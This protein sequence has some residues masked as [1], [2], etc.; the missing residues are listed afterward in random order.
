MLRQIS[1]LILVSILMPIFFI[2][3]GPAMAVSLSPSIS[4]S[5]NSFNFLDNKESDSMVQVV[6]F[7]ENE[8]R[9]SSPDKMAPLKSVDFKTR[10]KMVINDLKAGNSNLLES[11]S[12]QIV[13]LSPGVVIKRFWIAPALAFEIP[14]SKIDELTQIPGVVSIFENGA[15]EYIQPVESKLVASKTNGTY[16]HLSAMNIPALWDMGIDGTGRLICNFDTGVDGE[17]PALKSKWHGNSATSSSSWF[18]PHQSETLPQDMVGHGTQ[19]M[20]I[21]VG[22][23]DIDTIGVAPGA[24]WIGAAVVDQGQTLNKTISDILSAFEWVVDPDGDPET[25]ADMPDVLLNSWGIPTTIMEPCDE[26]FFQVIDNVEAAGIVTIFAAGNE[27]PTP[28]SLRNPANSARSPLNSFA[29]GAIDHNTNQIAS[30]SSRGPSSCDSSSIKPEVVAPGVGIYTTAKGGGYRYSTGTSMAAPIIAGLVVL[31]RQY[32]P[33]ATV[34]EIKNA[35]IESATDLG[36]QGEDNDYGHGL[37]DAVKALALLPRPSS[38]EIIVTGTIIGDDG[39]ADPEEIFNL[40]IRL[41]AV[42]NSF[43]SLTGYLYSNDARVNV[44]ANQ[45]PFIFPTNSIQAAN[46]PPYIL[47]VNGPILHGEVIAFK[48]AIDLPFGIPYD[49]L[50]FNLTIGTPPSGHMLTHVSSSVEMTVSDFGQYGMAENSIYPAGGRGFRYNGSDNLLYEAGIII[51]RNSLQLSSSIRDSLGRA[52]Q[53]DF[54]PVSDITVDYS[55]SSEGFKSFA[56]YTDSQADIQI[57]IT[58]GQTI[59]SF[60]QAGED[61][62]FIIRYFLKNSSG[63]PITDLSF[64]FFADFD[65]GETGDQIGI[66]SEN[67]LYYQMSDQYT[68]GV[69]PLTDIKGILAIDN[70]NEKLNI[71][72]LEKFGYLNHTGIEINETE[73]GD[74]MSILSFGPYNIQ[75]QDSVEVVLVIAVGQ[76]LTDIQYF[77]NLGAERYFGITD[78]ENQAN[79]LPSDFELGQNYPNPFNPATT[80]S[81]QINRATI[82]RLSI[83]NILGQEVA[84]IFEKQTEPGNYTVRWAGIDTN[85]SKVASGI[86]FY[87]LETDSSVDTKKMLMLK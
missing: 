15:I 6:L 21:M 72:N 44:I 42:A 66:L 38:P 58:I 69:L 60:N 34:E 57:P 47:R 74:Y 64:A 37:P 54:S 75:P 59:T 27:G 61:Q 4:K 46:I 70:G 56:E 41:S 81:F 51:G 50:S 10:H 84:V 82:A 16:S 68:I 1:F 73:I 48:L 79:L 19:T 23:T 17:H 24:E 76:S 5:L 80:I 8:N 12:A 63:E 53:S 52:D 28:Y 9:F 78:I 3:T 62:F 33:E 71:S 85:S 77:S 40:Y 43:D 65:L 14:L 83:I 30:F 26:T 31:M 39:I 2:G 45:A 11:I 49:T 35:L 7:A 22:A 25:V 36:Y 29:V 32:N 18:A 67:N 55:A 20:G 87:R 86:Y 13:S